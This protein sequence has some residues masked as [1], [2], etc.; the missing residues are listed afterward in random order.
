MNLLET[1]L[2]SWQPRRPSAG[3]SHRIF[4][5]PRSR[6]KIV[7]WSLRLAPAAACLLIALSALNPGRDIS[8]GAY[9]PDY[10]G[11]LTGS[12]QVASLGGNYRQEHNDLYA[13]TFDWT[14][15]SGSTSSITSFSPGKAN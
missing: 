9:H 10:A 4:S 3:L 13:V 1:Q 12:N 14:N 5:A 8:N 7:A 15:R 2:Q 6:P 11:F